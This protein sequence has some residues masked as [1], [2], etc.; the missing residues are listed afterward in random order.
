MYASVDNVAAEGSILSR[1]ALKMLSNSGFLAKARKCALTDIIG[2]CMLDRHSIESN[3]GSSAIDNF[4][5]S[6]KYE[7]RRP[8]V[9]VVREKIKPM[10]AKITPSPMKQWEK[11][12]TFDESRYKCHI[13]SEN[14]I[15]V[16]AAKP[17]QF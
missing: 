16:K 10:E 14:K 8:A 5:S 1:N 13:P 6:G 3:F 11:P 2:E 15:M 4:V 7:R 17:F 9:E 12:I